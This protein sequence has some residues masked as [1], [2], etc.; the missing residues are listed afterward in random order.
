MTTLNALFEQFK[1]QDLKLSW[2]EYHRQ[3][4]EIELDFYFANGFHLIPIAENGKVPVQGF[5]WK[6]AGGL[7]R[8]EALKYATEG[9]NLAVV[10][11]L[12]SPPLVI[13]DIDQALPPSMEDATKRTLTMKSPRGYAFFTTGKLDDKAWLKFKA[14]HPEFDLPRNSIMYQLVPL[15]KTC[16]ADFGKNHQCK[17]HDYRVRSWMDKSV[18]IMDFQRFVK[19]FG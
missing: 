11:G 16:T 10:A 2:R 14:R 4:W 5:K 9:S 1:T 19:E 17:R 6:E 8:E 7:T 12:S 13:F 15:S 3:L 18:P